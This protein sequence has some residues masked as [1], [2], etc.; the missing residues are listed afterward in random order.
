MNNIKR[1]FFRASDK[2]VINIRVPSLIRGIDY[3]HGLVKEHRY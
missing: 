1:G 2:K 3:Y